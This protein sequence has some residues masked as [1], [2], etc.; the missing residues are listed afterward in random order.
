MAA[1]PAT[2]IEPANALLVAFAK[3]PR[4]PTRPFGTVYVMAP[5]SA[6]VGRT[7][8]VLA[9]TCESATV[10]LVVA[11]VN[12]PESCTIVSVPP[13]AVTMGTPHPVTSHPAPARI[14]PAFGKNPCEL[15][16]PVAVKLVT[17]ARAVALFVR[18]AVPLAGKVRLTLHAT[19]FAPAAER[20][21]A[22]VPPVGL[23]LDDESRRKLLALSSRIV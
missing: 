16:G 2:P 15:P 7:T 13:P 10:P 9:C 11:S 23:K 1:P 14:V 3:M 18:S 22:N 8:L 6:P 19:S 20:L 12:S 21:I 5:V 17:S 4:Q